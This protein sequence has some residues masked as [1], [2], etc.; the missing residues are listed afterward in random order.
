MTLREKPEGL[1]GEK[2]TMLTTQGFAPGTLEQRQG[3]RQLLYGK[4]GEVR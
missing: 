4:E 2:A 1:R 3:G